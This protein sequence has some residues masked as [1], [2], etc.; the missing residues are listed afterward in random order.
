MSR[1]ILF[2]KPYDVLCQFRDKGGRPVLADF[3]PLPGFYPAGRL[4]HDSEGLL[5]LTDDG[6]LQSR[7]ADPR[8]KLP[9]TYWAQVDGEI[10]EEAL[11]R[12]RHG[13]QLKDG[14][15]LPARAERMDAPALRDRHPPIRYRASIPTSWISLTIREGR[16]RQVRRMTAAVGFPTLRLVR[17]AIGP[18]TVDGLEPGEWRESQVTAEEQRQLFLMPSEADISRSAGTTAARSERPM[19]SSD[20]RPRRRSPSPRPSGPSRPPTPSSRKARG[21]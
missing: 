12:L 14:R 20:P 8:W 3:I 13:V 5:L 1:L 11:E 21:S 4:D 15:T 7:I 17:V 10:D 6:V 19:P 18:W 2:N 16:N 9:K